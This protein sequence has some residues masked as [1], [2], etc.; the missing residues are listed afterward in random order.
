MKLVVTQPFADRRVGDSITDAD[1][2]DA[3]LETHPSYVVKA[4]DDP[5]PETPVSDAPDT[6]LLPMS[7]P[8]A[9]APLPKATRR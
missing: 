2:I 6:P 9:A 5:Q 1:Q 4:P 8:A 7:A 3:V